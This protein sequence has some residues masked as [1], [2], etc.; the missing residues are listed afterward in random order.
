MATPRTGNREGRPAWNLLA[1]NDRHL[2]AFFWATQIYE[3]QICKNTKA[4]RHAVAMT[5]AAVQRGYLEVEEGEKGKPSPTN[6]ATM[7]ARSGKLTFRTN[8]TESKDTEHLWNA[9]KAKADDIRRKA[10]RAMKSE[11]FE[12]L[13]VMAAAMIATFYHTDLESALSIAMEHCSLAREPEFFERSLHP[14]IIGRFDPT[15]RVVLKL[16]EFMPN[17]P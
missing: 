10:E 7:R 16:P 8:A 13:K 11:H 5:L 3:S 2:I 15:K 6:L 9:V 17:F 4:T 12:W 1:D 14:F